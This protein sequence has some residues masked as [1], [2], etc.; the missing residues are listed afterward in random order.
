[1]GIKEKELP[2]ADPNQLVVDLSQIFKPPERLSVAQA[3]AKYLKVSQPGQPPE[4]WNP[5]TTPY[6]VEPM[7]TLTSRRH[8]GC[9]FVG[10][11]RTGKTLGLLEGSI[12]YTTI[13]DPADVMVVQMD[14]DC[15]RDY[16]VTRLDRAIEASPELAKRI[17]PTFGKDNVYDKWFT[18]GNYL[19]LGWPNVKQLSGRE[20]RFMLLTDFDRMP[21]NVNGEGDPFSLSAKRTTTFMSRGMTMA[22]SSPGYELLDPHWEPDPS[23]PHEAPPVKGILGLYNMGDRRRWYWQCSECKHYWEA[24]FKHLQFDPEGRDFN[25]EAEN[26]CIACGE[27][28]ALH[29][30]GKKKE[31]NN[32]GIWVPEGVEVDTHGKFFGDPRDSSIASFWMKGPSAG[33]QTWASLV[34]KYLQAKA[35]FDRTGNEELLKTTINTDQGLPYLPAASSNNR[36]PKTLKDRA[37]DLGVRVVPKGVRFLTASFDVQAGRNRRFVVQVVGWGKDR[38]NW[39]IDRYNIKFS[40]RFLDPSNEGMDHS[41]INEEDYAQY[42]ERIDP[43]G[44]PEDWHVI[45]DKVIKRSYELDDNSGRAMRVC[46]VT[47]DSGGEHGVTDNAYTFYRHLR[48]KGLHSAFKLVKG[49]STQT[50]KRI[51]ESYPDNTKRKDRKASAR[52]DVPL[53][54]TN[55]HHFKDLIAGAMNRADDGHMTMHFPDW[56]GDWFYNELTYEI[57]TSK[58]WEK[59]GKGPNEAFDLYVYNLVAAIEKGIEKINWERPPPWAAE[60][61]SNINVID[62]EDARQDQQKAAVP[63]GKPRRRRTRARFR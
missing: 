39:L 41:E 50:A 22:E 6:M 7:N 62:I 14:E 61:D 29:E 28:G 12:C 31:M 44:H 49:A 2:F 57:R 35:E 11:A 33:Y 36:S 51:A 52:G 47:G 17:N 25:Y 58:G 9:V 21:L 48:Q 15:A 60:W 27:C 63:S 32:N 10:P 30:P 3:A 59:P 34:M 19:K 16:S 26:A 4:L 20:F 46:Y 54:V 40:R 1:M 43:A 8:S 45:I 38:Q 55:V 42:Y 18:A 37:E 5:E 56:I 24:D 13:C 23:H 53:L